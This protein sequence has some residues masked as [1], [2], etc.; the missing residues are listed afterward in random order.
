MGTGG[1][2]LVEREASLA[3]EVEEKLK[4]GVKGGLQMGL[5]DRSRGVAP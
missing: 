2:V 5:E 1:G 3:Q 4:R